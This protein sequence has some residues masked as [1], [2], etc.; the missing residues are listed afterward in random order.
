[1]HL[2]QALLQLL[3]RWLTWKIN[4]GG[5]FRINCLTPVGTLG[6]IGQ[7]VRCEI[8]VDPFTFLDASVYHQ[9][10]ILQQPNS[11]DCGPHL[12]WNALQLWQHRKHVDTAERVRINLTQVGER[13]ATRFEN[14][15]LSRICIVCCTMTWVIMAVDFK[16]CACA[17]R[18]YLK[19]KP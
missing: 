2:L 6:G 17:I 5:S 12:L 19:A 7:P 18:S 1:M 10:V 8:P 4:G 3:N 9:Q 11:T 14:A 13:E 16:R 15:L